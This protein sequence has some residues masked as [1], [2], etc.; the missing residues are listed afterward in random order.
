MTNEEKQRLDRVEDPTE[1]VRVRQS[2]LAPTDVPDWLRS[3]AETDQGG[4][5]AGTEKYRVLSRVKVIQGTSKEE[6][7]NTYGIGGVILVPDMERVCKGPQA[8]G[9]TEAEKSFKFVPMLFF[10][11]FTVQ[12]DLKDTAS[13]FIAERTFNDNSEI[14]KKARSADTRQERYGELDP[15]TQQPKF[16]R[17]FVEHLCFIGVIYDHKH[18]LAGRPICI[19]FEKGE[20]GTGTRFITAFRNRRAGG[21]P[22]P[23]WAQ[24]WC[25]RPKLRQRGTN[26]WRGLDFFNPPADELYI[27]QE[28]GPTFKEWHNRLSEELKEERLRVDH[29]GSEDEEVTATVSENA[30]L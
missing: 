10:N 23:L 11:E 8:E 27:R 12:N 4:S 6:L 9:A 16:Q 7:Q 13:P 26:S 25:F 17:R 5:L 2:V 18:P 20:F 3:E 15:N 22:V 19:T 14:A 24:V 1:M 29:S 28:E 21:H 30:E